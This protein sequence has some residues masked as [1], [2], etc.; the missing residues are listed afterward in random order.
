MKRSFGAA[1]LLLAAGAGSIVA[2]QHLPPMT[3][4]ATC[5]SFPARSFLP[6]VSMLS[7]SCRTAPRM[8]AEAIFGF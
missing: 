2:Q 3:I 1:T 5:A 8:A 7:R 6:T 4:F